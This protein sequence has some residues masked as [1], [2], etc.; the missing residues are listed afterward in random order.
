MFCDFSILFGLS[1]ILSTFN[2]G[3]LPKWQHALYISLRF[4]RNVYVFDC[5]TC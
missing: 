5:V 2:P 1:D 4:I 3:R